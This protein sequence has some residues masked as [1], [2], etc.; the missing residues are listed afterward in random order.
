MQACL[1]LASLI[2]ISDPGRLGNEGEARVVLK[3]ALDDGDAFERALLRTFS[4][5]KGPDNQVQT[6]LRKRYQ[7][8]S[9]L[10][11]ISRISWSFLTKTRCC[12][13]SH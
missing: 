2:A 13:E 1:P 10:P 3:G 11:Y 6:E 7:R 9:K 4:K 8:I 5:V 12:V